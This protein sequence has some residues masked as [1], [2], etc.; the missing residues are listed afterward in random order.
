[1]SA[2]CPICR[3]PT[4][5]LHNQDAV[6]CPQ[7]GM[8]S[9]QQMVKKFIPAQSHD[10]MWTKIPEKWTPSPYLTGT[11]QMSITFDLVGATLSGLCANPYVMERLTHAVE[12]QA[13]PGTLEENVAKVLARTAVMIARATQRELDA[14][15]N[16]PF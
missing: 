11:T 1:M 5:V 12:Q 7:H 4:R 6:I 15:D 14:S 3:K 16:I 9:G 13:L 2:F 10:V 8:I